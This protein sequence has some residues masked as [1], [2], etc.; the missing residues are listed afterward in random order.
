MP[1]ASK[2]NSLRLSRPIGPAPED[3]DCVEERCKSS[4]SM[5]GFSSARVRYKFIHRIKGYNH[6]VV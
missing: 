4:S 1:N 2:S 3:D 5:S 6:R